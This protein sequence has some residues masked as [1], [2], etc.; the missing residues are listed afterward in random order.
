[1][2]G[3]PTIRDLAKASG[4]SVA[5]VDR[6]LNQRLKVREVTIARVID[7]A[8][9]IGF[10]AAPLLAAR[11]R[12]QAPAATF[13]FLLLQGEDAFYGALA[14]A[15][16]AATRESRAVRGKAIIEFM[17]D[18]SPNAIVGRILALGA[19]VEALA[20]VSVD[21]PHVTEAIATLR[22]RGVSTFALLT[23]LTAPLRGG[24]VGR[25]NRKEG[26][27]AGFMVTRTAAAAGKIGIIIGSH[28][29]LCQETAES[30]FRSYLRE[31]APAF[32]PLE[33]LVNLED[34]RLARRA[35]LDLLRHNADL[36]GLYICGGGAD[37]V[38]AAAREVGGSRRIAI[39]CNE[40]TPTT[41]LAL[42]DGVL[43]AVVATRVEAMAR[44]A[45]EA[46]GKAMLS[47]PPERPGE[48]LVPFDLLIAEN[49]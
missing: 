2:A 35:T 8:Q 26:R 36:V 12:D 19:R 47:G 21:H 45:V 25:D 10:H 44:G 9:A 14:R 20:V 13:G 49:V 5:T 24:Y 32:Q 46:M 34:P 16:A 37:G 3:R 41:R 48:I 1:M 17:D 22:A 15:L 28:R 39:V 42:I 4:L 6:V 27:S 18:L 29:F 40:I 33:S 31:H 38:I 7:A 11:I 23:D 43:T 30:S